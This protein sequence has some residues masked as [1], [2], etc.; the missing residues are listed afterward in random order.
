MQKL[1]EELKRSFAVAAEERQ[2]KQDTIAK[3]NASIQQCQQKQR[4][5]EYTDQDY[6][7]LLHAKEEKIQKLADEKKGLLAQV[8]HFKQQSDK[9]MQLLQDAKMDS[10]QRQAELVQQF[11]AEFED[12][13]Q[14]FVAE[15][16][17]LT[18]Q[19]DK[20][21]KEFKLKEKQ[22]EI[23]KTEKSLLKEQVDKL[24]KD[25]AQVKTHNNKMG[26]ELQEARERLET[27]EA[28]TARLHDEVLAKTA[29]V[30]QYKKQTDSYKLKIEEAQTEKMIMHE[31]TEK[32]YK[33]RLT[34]LNS[35]LQH[36]QL[37][38]RRCQDQVKTLEKNKVCDLRFVCKQRKL[39]HNSASEYTFEN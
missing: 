8:N 26:V 11:Q 3:L 34:E 5:L 33:E 12:K 4:Q 13:S 25:I 18:E 38:L 27:S 36:K 37:D 35:K 19:L 10:T 28:D 9:N 16:L 21:V 20:T 1:E 17:S 15:K 24:D 30:K 14:L 32:R 39:V 31:A 22:L 2:K 7:R 23:A 6:K 29:Q